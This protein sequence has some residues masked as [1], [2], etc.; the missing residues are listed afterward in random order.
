MEK[1]QLVVL[2]MTKDNWILSHINQEGGSLFTPLNLAAAE[3]LEVVESKGTITLTEVISS[4]QWP[5]PM[6]LMGVGGLIRD[7][8]ITAKRHDK[9]IVLSKSV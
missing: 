9:N 4:T 3:A 2:P 6:V 5:E 7:G 1:V 8:I